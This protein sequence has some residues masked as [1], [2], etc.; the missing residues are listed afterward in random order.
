VRSGEIVIEPKE[1]I[2]KRLGRSP[3]D[4]DAIVMALSEGDA[5]LMRQE[6]RG[7]LLP[8]VHRGHE[9]VKQRYGGWP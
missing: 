2:R 7:G 3:D 5:A 8:T 6:R 9:A 1:T 4:G